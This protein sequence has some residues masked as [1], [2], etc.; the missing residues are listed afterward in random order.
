MLKIQTLVYLLTRTLFILIV[1]V[2]ILFNT[3]PNPNYD[4]DEFRTTCEIV[5]ARGFHCEKHFVLT[6]QGYILEV[7]RIVTPY[8]KRKTCHP[9]ILQHGLTGT[10][11][12]F[13]MAS[14]HVPLAPNV[15]GQNLGFELAKR[16][17]DVWLSNYRG[18][19]YGMQHVSLSSSDEQ[20]WNFT[21]DEISRF[22][23]PAVIDYVQLAT[24]HSKVSYIGHSQGTAVMF[25]LLSDPVLSIKY[26]DV[27]QPFVAISPI[28]R[29]GNAT[30]IFRHLV[31]TL[32]SF[33]SSNEGPAFLKQS[34]LAKFKSILCNSPFRFLCKWYMFSMY[35][36]NDQ[37]NLTRLAVYTAHMGSTSKRNLRHFHQLF[38]SNRFA[39]FDHGPEGNMQKFGQK[40]SPLYDLTQIRHNSIHVIYSLNDLFA[41]LD[42]VEQLSK[43]IANLK[44][45]YEIQDAQANHADPLIGTDVAVEVNNKILNILKQYK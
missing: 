31:K 13:I 44:E 7:H 39:R 37:T 38:S 12:N 16:G 27:I 42:G 28:T 17:R 14:P 30:T 6:H 43:D 20:F 23:M 9:V 26:N 4:A 29:I 15:V 18:N 45:M 19:D 36:Y 5:T 34:G 40:E 11:S 33:S 1:V 35:G 2:A 10:S 41:P 8:F 32:H 22:D 21:F 24:N 25:A 3:A